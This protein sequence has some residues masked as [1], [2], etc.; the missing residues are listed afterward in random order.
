MDLS[1]ST[2]TWSAL[3]WSANSS[4]VTLLTTPGQIDGRLD[5]RVAT[6]DHG[7]VLPLKSGPSQC[8]A[9]G[10]ALV[11]YSASPGTFMLRQRAP[12]PG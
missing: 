10:D 6:A 12:V 9:V 2:S 1:L 7:H 11:R 8:R 5:A 3:S 4:R